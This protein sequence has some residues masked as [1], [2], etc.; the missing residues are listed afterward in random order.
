M[1][2][3]DEVLAL[4][5]EVTRLAREVREEKEAKRTSNRRLRA[6]IAL[7]VLFGGYGLWS[8]NDRIDQIIDVRTGS[9]AVS[10]VDRADIARAHNNLVLGIVTRDFTRP[11]PVELHEGVERQLVP[12]PDCTTPQAVADFYEGR[13]TPTKPDIASTPTSEPTTVYQP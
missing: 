2:T 7:F 6:V 8:N 4:T 11:V 9:R 12:V 13:T 3:S 1:A 10:C 5:K